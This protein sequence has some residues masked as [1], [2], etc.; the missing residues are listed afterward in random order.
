MAAVLT[1]L[2][3][4][5]DEDLQ[6]VSRENPGWSFERDDAGALVV[7]PTGTD[8][9]AKSGEAFGQLRDW[10]KAGPGGKV[11]DSS[12][13]FKMPTNAVRSPDAAWISRERAGSFGPSQM[14]GYRE[15]VPDVVIEV[16]S[17]TDTWDDVKDK[18]HAFHRFGARYAVAIDPYAREV[19]ELGEPPSG[20]ALDFDA[21]I[22]A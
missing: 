19:Y 12:T 9:G 15:V 8:G 21:I 3:P 6:R 10:A 7:S 5:S 4:F 17:P 1:G 2:A 11:Y 18:I 20:L 16:A 13:G 22:D 14:R